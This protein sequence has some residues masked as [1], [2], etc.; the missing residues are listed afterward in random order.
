MVIIKFYTD[1]YTPL[2]FEQFCKSG[3]KF[4]GIGTEWILLT[5]EE[6]VVLQRLDNK[7]NAIKHYRLIKSSINEGWVDCL[8]SDKNQR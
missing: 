2:W 5:S 7:R 6:N 8:K 3:L 4:V 1:L